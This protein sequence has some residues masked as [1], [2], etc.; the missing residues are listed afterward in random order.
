VEAF[1]GPRRVLSPEDVAA[2]GLHLIVDMCH[3]FPERCL[4][5]FKTS[6]KSVV[7]IHLSEGREGQQHMPVSDYGYD[8]V[9]A[10]RDVNWSGSV[11]LEYLPEYGASL[12]PDC[13]RLRDAYS[14][15]P[16]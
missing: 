2:R 9:Q 3:L 14:V 15:A 6:I 1:G 13:R 16:R 5:L 11:I 12:I 8:M 4:D 10:L 7:G